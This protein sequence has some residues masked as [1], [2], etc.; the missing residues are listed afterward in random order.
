[1]QLFEIETKTRV[2]AAWF[3][4]R[5]AWWQYH[6]FPL[7][8]PLDDLYASLYFFFKETL[9]SFLKRSWRKEHLANC[10]LHNALKQHIY[11]KESVLHV[12]KWNSHNYLIWLR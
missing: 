7:N 8:K 12:G 11:G 5:K 10:H 3:K 9:I 6:S 2:P 1:M 4:A